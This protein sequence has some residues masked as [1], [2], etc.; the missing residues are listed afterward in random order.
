M[1]GSLGMVR[2]LVNIESSTEV[3]RKSWREPIL[4]FKSK[5]SGSDHRP[6]PPL[7]LTNQIAL[8]S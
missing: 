5:L 2:C 8:G 1:M 4:G 6:L 7:R 3:L